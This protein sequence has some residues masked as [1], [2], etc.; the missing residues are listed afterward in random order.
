M[1]SFSGS[2]DLCWPDLDQK[3]SA[4]HA[5]WPTRF[6]PITGSST[7]QRSDDGDAPSLSFQRLSEDCDLGLRTMA[8]AGV[9]LT[10]HMTTLSSHFTWSHELCCTTL[11]LVPSPE[12]HLSPTQRRT[13]PCSPALA[14][15][16]VRSST[17]VVLVSFTFSSTLHASASSAPTDRSCP[18]NIPGD[19]ACEIRNR[20]LNVIEANNGLW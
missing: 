3:M 20:A 11:P 5:R 15:S 18:I 17:P 10:T 14:N 19:A 13:L 16:T 6:G 9:W 2:S 8:V 4:D 12:L 1:P 7:T